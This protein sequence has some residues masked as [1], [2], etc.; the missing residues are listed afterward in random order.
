MRRIVSFVCLLATAAGAALGQNATSFC[1]ATSVPALVRQ[2]GIAELLGDIVLTCNAGATGGTVTGNLGVLLSVNATNRLNGTLLSG[3]TLSLDN[4]SGTP[5]VVSSTARLANPSTVE[6]DGLSIPLTALSAFQLRISGIRGNATAATPGPVGP[7]ITAALTYSGGVLVTQNQGLTV[8]YT[9]PTIGATLQSTGVRFTEKRSTAFES[10]AKAMANGA[11]TGTRIVVNYSGF[12]TGVSVAV[13]DAIAGSS[14]TEPTSAGVFGI[15]ASGGM[16]TPATPGGTLLLSRVDGADASGAGGVPVFNP[17]G[18]APIPLTTS[19][20]V[21]FTNGGGYAVYEVIDE[22]PAVVESAQFGATLLFGPDWQPGTGE[23]NVSLAPTSAVLQADVMAP[24]P[25]FIANTPDLDCADLGDCNATYFPRLAVDPMTVALTA[26]TGKTS[27]TQ[28]VRVYNSSHGELTYKYSFSYTDGTGWLIFNQD[29]GKLSA[30]ATNLAPGVYNGAL[31]LDGG[32]LAGSK[33]VPVVLTVTEPAPPPKQ[34]P[35]LVSVVNAAN[36]IPGPV[37]AG[38]L[39]SIFGQKLGPQPVVAFHGQAAQVL[40]SDNTQINAMVP[41]A[42]AGQPSANVTVTTGEG[43]NT[44][45]PVALARFAPA[46]F[47]ALTEDYGL[48]TV[49]H[50]APTGSVLQIFLTGADTSAN[51]VITVKVHDRDNLQPAYAGPA[52][53]IPG[54]QQVNVVVPRDLPA[55]QSEAVVCVAADANSQRVC[56]KP[57]TIWLSK[58]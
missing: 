22:N 27:P 20:P 46:I 43:S 58:P 53:G 56:G 29:N 51:G 54:L 15:A 21:P 14:A 19:T 17:P 5:T 3:V 1:T 25:R 45:F 24:I 13:P 33:T 30:D 36:W 28:Y 50:R 12:P 57:L 39:V 44:P 16:Y 47:G 32:P 35:V 34:P 55:M 37:Q 2:E 26:E 10:R 18:T 48:N 38:S 7:S 52:P 23:V 40:Y 11:D 8:G 9:L 4:G 49:D 31:I 41:A 6:F 42:L